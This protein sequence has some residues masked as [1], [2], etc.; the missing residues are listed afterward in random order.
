M[1]VVED[2][3]EIQ[4]LELQKETPH[5]LLQIR[6][7]LEEMEEVKAMEEEGCS[8][9]FER[10]CNNCGKYGHKQTNCHFFDGE[11]RN[12]GKYRH[13]QADCLLTTEN[14]K[15]ADSTFMHKEGNGDD[16]VSF[17]TCSA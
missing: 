13:K 11:C 10:D 8:S 4:K 15:K 17:L 7:E 12:C 1:V 5:I 6:E 9:F 2:E 16:G 14:N 3:E